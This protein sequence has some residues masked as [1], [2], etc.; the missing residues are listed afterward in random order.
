ME[1]TNNRLICLSFTGNSVGNKECYEQLAAIPNDMFE[2]PIYNKYR[3]IQDRFVTFDQRIK[4]CLKLKSVPSHIESC[5]A[6]LEYKYEIGFVDEF[7][8]LILGAKDHSA[9]PA[10]LKKP[11][12]FQGSNF[13][14]VELED[15]LCYNK[16]KMTFNSIPYQTLTKH[17]ESADRGGPE[18]AQFLWKDTN[19][20]IYIMDCAAFTA[21]NG[22]EHNIHL[23]H[24]LQ[25]K[26]LKPD[27]RLN[28]V[29]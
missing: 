23:H 11:Y 10:K 9:A 4:D 22:T 15:F 19:V 29:R 14:L 5:L 26:K 17:D 21:Y 3:C 13:T 16:T 18:E 27:V 2:Y 24:H 20:Q 7:S 12:R 1:Q 25:H 8:Y 6:A 28:Q